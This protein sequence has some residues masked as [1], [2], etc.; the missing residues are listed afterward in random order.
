[1]TFTGDLLEL[2]CR[3]IADLVS[4]AYVK[5]SELRYVAV[6]RAYAEFFGMDISDFIGRRSRELFD[7]PEEEDR[8]DKE[9]RALVFASEE[10]AICFDAV[11]N[12]HDRVRI[13]SFTVSEDRVYVLGLFETTGRAR[14]RDV[15]TFPAMDHDTEAEL[16]RS[17]M[18]ALP[19]AAFVRDADHRLI[20]ANAC[21]EAFTGKVRAEMLGKTEQEMF[22][23]AAGG[24]V[25]RGNLAALET[26]EAAEIESLLPG[27]GGKL[28]PILARI[29]RIDRPEGKRYVV[30]SFSD[31]SLLKDRERE[32]IAAQVQ[33]EI[34]HRD[35]ASI[36]NSLPVGVLILESDLTILYGNEAFYTISDLPVN[37]FEGRPFMELVEY[38]HGLGRYSPGVTAEEMFEQRVSQF[39]SEVQLPPAEI[40]WGSRSLLVES[41]RVSKDR[42]LLTYADFSTVRRHEQEIHAAR[43]ALESLGELMGDATH[44]MSQGLLVV[45]DEEIL[46]SNDALAG[47]LDV[48]AEMLTIGSDWSKLFSFCAARGDFTEDA[49]GV[50]EGLRQA[51]A[52]GLPASQL[53][54][55]ADSRWVKM[56]VSV[57]ERRHGVALFTDITTMKIREEDLTVLLERAEAADKVKSEFLANMSHEIR[58]PMNGVLGMAELLAKTNL[59]TRQKTFIDIIVKS[60]NALM[61]IINDILDFSKIDSGQ[62]TL[63]RTTFDPVEAVEDVVTLL[64]S[65]AAEKGIELLVRAAPGLPMAIIGDAGRFRQVVTNLVGNAVKFTER[66]HVLVDLDYKSGAADEIM[67][68]LRIEDTG[69]GMPKDRLDSIFGKFSQIDSSSTRRHEGTGL[70]LAITSGLVD[71]FGGYIDVDSEPRKGSVFTVSL[72]F[73]IA[74]ARLDPK[75]LPINVKNA[76]VLVIDDNAVNRQILTEQL[77][78]WGFDGAAAEDGVEGL[79][80]LEAAHGCGMEIDAIVLDYQIPGMNGADIARKLRADPRYCDL[81]IIFLTSM[82]ISGTEKE[83]A[84][85]NGQ[86][87]LMKPARANVLRNTIVEVVRT[88]R[89]RKATSS[90][91]RLIVE[92][93]EPEREDRPETPVPSFIDVLV[94]EDNDVNQIVFTQILQATGLKFLVVNN[95]Q[96][97][98]DAWE[99]HTPRIIMMDVSMPVLNGHDATRR[100]RDLERGQGHRVPIIGVTAHALESDRELCFDA[101]MDDYMSK[102]ISPEL[103]EEKIAHWLGMSEEPS[104]DL[105]LKGSRP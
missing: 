93:P 69:I 44:A 11:G 28:H 45:Q 13:E 37:R 99:A 35:M 21:Y 17:I 89:I 42:I 39:R 46:L 83:F 29:N 70:G 82:D 105:T 57:S 85:L 3:R 90:G 48:P 78:L 5:N 12:A 97:A 58:T 30:G 103:L 84:A 75:P 66:G 81:P 80:I 51:L 56:D 55:V 34:L 63:R 15:P 52:L 59:D 61:T 19:V 96:E 47:M 43:E 4:P 23:E 49:A 40:N 95:G 38:N 71:L 101:G 76:R 32:L 62:M 50:L 9:R 1:M 10:S 20:Y 88:N 14:R 25:H 6:N 33:T 26:G 73:T 68:I 54:R 104:G 86:A 72:P 7:R 60:G 53:F 22:G 94:A 2:A 36:L 91:A 102:P 27:A 92:A 100:I 79:A 16:L 18:E 67:A 31:V 8:E 64:S 77:S 98:V 24:V 87:H 74:A 41:R 65:L